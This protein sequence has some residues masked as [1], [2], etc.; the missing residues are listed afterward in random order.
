VQSSVQVREQN[1]VVALLP[2]QRLPEEQSVGVVQGS[3]K[4]AVPRE[5]S[6]TC[7]AQPVAQVP[8]LG[9]VAEPRRQLLL[10]PHQ[11]QPA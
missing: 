4:A 1:A 3:P 10:A 6:A 8:T 2:T 7:Q 5:Q 9:P 11:P